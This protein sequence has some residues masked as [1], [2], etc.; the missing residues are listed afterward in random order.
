MKKVVG[1]VCDTQEGCHTHRPQLTPAAQEAAVRG[2]AP[3]EDAGFS[4]KQN[5]ISRLANRCHPDRSWTD[6]PG[7][8]SEQPRLPMSDQKNSVPKKGYRQAKKRMR[9]TL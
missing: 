6:T 2:G 5:Q 8:R 4:K 1:S 7:R 3:G 9:M